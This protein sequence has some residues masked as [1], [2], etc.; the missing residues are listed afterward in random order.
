MYELYL[1]VKT[2]LISVNA[3]SSRAT[4]RNSRYSNKHV[5]RNNVNS[6]TVLVSCYRYEYA[7]DRIPVCRGCVGGVWVGVGVCM[8]V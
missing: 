6:S 1:S 4:T 7:D 5:N 8:W 2:A 3:T